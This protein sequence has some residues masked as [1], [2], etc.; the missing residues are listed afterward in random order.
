MTT[1]HPDAPPEPREQPPARPE[2]VAPTKEERA[3][4]RGRRRLWCSGIAVLVLVA[5][6]PAAISYG[7]ALTYPGNASFLV[8]SVEWVRDHGGAPLVN[9]AEN[10][11]YRLNAPSDSP[12]DPAALPTTSIPTAPGAPSPLATLRGTRALPGEGVWQAGPT[13]AGRSPGLYTTFI[14]PDPQHASVVAG[15]AR[16]DQSSVAARLIPGTKEPS[17]QGWPEGGQVPADMRPQLVA[18]FN[19][20]FKMKDANGGFLADGRTAVP[21]RAGA[22]SLVVDQGGRVRVGRWGRDVG[23][24]P[25]VVAVRQNLE[26]IIDGGHVVP[27]LD[28]NAGGRWGSASNQLQYTWRSGVGLDARGDLIY[29]GG[30]GMTL[31]TLATALAQAGATTAMQLDIHGQM[32]GLFAY[33]HTASGQPAGT[34]LLPTMPGPQDRYLTPDQRDFL[35]IY[36]R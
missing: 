1:T 7:R 15:V 5:S 12:P 35:A 27:G 9:L 34:P 32:V 31:R 3:R 36:A 11:Y 33:S 6:A 24:G 8:R 10:L 28:I 4:R 13:V 18:T 25:D 17:G 14:R 19:S 20:G 16:F 22:A 26:L 2:D 29:V 30:A 21:L 23:P